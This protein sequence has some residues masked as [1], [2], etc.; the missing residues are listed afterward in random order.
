M[1]EKSYIQNS[2][3]DSEPAVA[4]RTIFFWITFSA[5]CHLVLILVMILLPEL[6]PAKRISAS[7]I[8]V[9]LVSVPAKG[10]PSAPVRVPAAKAVRKAAPAPAPPKSSEAVSISPSKKKA[11]KSLKHK[12]FKSSKVVKSAVTRLEKKVEETRHPS[13]EEALDRLKGEVEKSD[14]R[15]RVKSKTTDADTPQGSGGT[16][17]TDLSSA[18][19]LDRIRIY[20]AEIAYQIQKQWAFSEQLAGMKSEVEAL[21]GIKIMPDGEIKD[22]WFD[23]KS[24]NRHLD[25]S[26]YRAVMKSN[27]LPPLPPGL[28][29]TPYVV[30]FRFGPKGLKR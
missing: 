5:V 21:V 20:Q 15:Q 22:V 26:A 10:Q 19:S 1:A 6:A 12:T 29:N 13:L 3:L 8:N 18:G 7:V 14:S 30:G 23:Q 4:S 16:A 28:F 27:P 17:S 24:G 9:S 2:G 11:K 25:E